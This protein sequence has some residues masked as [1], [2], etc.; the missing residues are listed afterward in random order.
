MN[1]RLLEQ[2][3]IVMEAKSGKQT[4]EDDDD[5]SENASIQLYIDPFTKKVGGFGWMNEFKFCF[6]QFPL[7]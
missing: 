1:A 3:T 7:T 5:L 2:N 4:G 6:A